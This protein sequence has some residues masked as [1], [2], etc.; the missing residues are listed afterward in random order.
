MSAKKKIKQRWFVPAGL[1]PTEMDLK[2]ME[3]QEK[4]KIVPTRDLIKT[5]E[6]IEGIRQ[7]GV[8]NT[9]VL[10][11]VA[12]KIHEGMSTQEIDQLVYDF[13][14][15]HGGV[16][17]PLHYEGFPNSCC[18]SI[19]DVV[20]HGIP[21]ADDILIEGDIINVDCTTILN[22]YYADASRMFVI[23]KTT[24]ERQRL[25]D[26]AWNCLKAGEKVCQQPYVFVGDI[27]NAVAKL[28]HANGYTVVR[29]LCGHGV[30]VEFHEEPD[31]VHYGR[32]GTGMLL[33]PGMTFT[34]EPMINEGDWEVCGDAEDPTEWIVLTEDGTDS[35]QWEH[36]YL[37]TENGVEILTH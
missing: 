12:E 24:P 5:H 10:D 8:L 30:G 9:A 17:A 29:D 26:V 11:L 16:P 23:G 25:V 18:T 2:I 31:V 35:A 34:I 32:K 20:C 14:T 27:G 15:K 6:Q 36:T 13:T 7:A 22:G 37:M 21:S 19:N 3:W 28:A 4:G 1:E 33:V